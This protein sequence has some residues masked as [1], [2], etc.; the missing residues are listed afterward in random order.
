VVGLSMAFFHPYL[1]T[2]FDLMVEN[3]YSIMYRF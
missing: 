3:V 2:A 1:S